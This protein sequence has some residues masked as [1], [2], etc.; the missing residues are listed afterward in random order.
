VSGFSRT[1]W[2]HVDATD[3]DAALAAAKLGPQFG[4]A[5]QD[6]SDEV[7]KML[8]FD[9]LTKVTGKSVDELS[10]PAAK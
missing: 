1:R 9:L 7:D 5:K 10:K 2:I 8:D 4:Y 3:I 6:Y